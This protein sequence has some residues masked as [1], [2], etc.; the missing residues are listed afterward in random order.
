MVC[1]NIDTKVSIGKMKAYTLSIIQDT[2][3]TARADGTT[4]SVDK[5]NSGRMEMFL[6]SRKNAAKRRARAIIPDMEKDKGRP[7]TA[8]PGTSE[9]FNM[10]S[11]KASSPSFGKTI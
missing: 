2:I 3:P 6:L 10:C 9:T 4:R 5:V 8:T 11:R 7:I 1:E